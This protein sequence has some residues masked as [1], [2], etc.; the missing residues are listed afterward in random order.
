MKRLAF[1]AMLAILA[2]PAA[3]QQYKWKDASGRTQYGDIP[4]PG[5]QAER[6]SRSNVGSVSSGASTTSAAGGDAA[7]PA[8]GPKS[9]AEMEQEFRKR[10][11]EAE[12]KQK[13]DEKLAQESRVKQENC[14]RAKRELASLESGVRQTR[15]NDKGER[16]FLD[17]A[18]IDAQKADARRAVSEWCR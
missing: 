9:A 15:V 5:V 1:F 4:P 3:A 17:D 2:L 13:K 14:S 18:Q 7:K 10:R 16:E 11:M 8:S 12:D 6:L